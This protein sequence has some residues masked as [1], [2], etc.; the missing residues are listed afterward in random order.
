[1][2]LGGV[3]NNNFDSSSRRL[4]ETG[5]SEAATQKAQAAGKLDESA[6]LEGAAVPAADVVEGSEKAQHQPAAAAAVD[7]ARARALGGEDD[8]KQRLLKQRSDEGAGPAAPARG[9]RPDTEWLVARSD[10]GSTRPI[11]RPRPKPPTGGSIKQ[12][13][14]VPTGPI[15]PNATRI[16]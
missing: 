3:N 9:L 16:V 12:V 4:Q 2:S 1:M 11:P 7:A 14:N 15:D 6:R 5:G 13:Q 8:A 10:R